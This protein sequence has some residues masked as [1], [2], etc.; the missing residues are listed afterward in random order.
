MTR[1]RFLRQEKFASSRTK[2]REILLK[3]KQA[4]RCRL[5]CFVTLVVFCKFYLR[6]CESRTGWIV[7][8]ATHDRRMDLVV[9]TIQLAT[10]VNVRRA[11][12]EGCGAVRHG[13]AVLNID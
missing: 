8:I 11:H 10:V 5:A 9:A 1:G 3:Q 7:R 12:A 13:G 2:N 4:S 6:L